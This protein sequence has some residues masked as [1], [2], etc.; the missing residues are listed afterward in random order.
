MNEVV[1]VIGVG[2][3]GS[4]GLRPQALARI[5]AAEF[6]AGG[7]R[8]L[9]YFPDVPAERFVIKGE[10]WSLPDE[11]RSRLDRKQRCVVLASGDPLFYGIGDYLARTLGRDYVRM[12]PT[13][14]SMQ[15]AFARARLRWDGARLSS[16]HGRDLRP[17]LLQLL[18]F[19]TIGLFSHDG[20]SPAE[21]ARFFLRYGASE[22]HALV[23]EN[24][25]AS[26]ERVT[27]CAS[28]VELV[29]QRFAPLN[30]LILWHGRVK[31]SVQTELRRGSVPGVQDDLFARPADGLEVMTRQEVRSVVLGKLC[32]PTEPGDT[33]WDIGAGLGTV[34]LEMAVL[35]PHLEVLAVEKD[36][37]RLEFLRENRKQFA[38]YNV[39]VIEGTAPEALAEE[40]E[41]PKLVFLGGS[42]G[43][44]AAILD[45]VHERLLHGGRLVANFVT[46]EHLTEMLARV[47][48]W[49]WQFEVTEISVSRSDG[50]AGLT[51]LKPQRSVFLVQADKPG[52]GHA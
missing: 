49:G 10:L 45:L 32:W 20:D 23:A 3:D 47:K 39:R 36:A 34:S 21:V 51:G 13:V 14:S 11:L 29:D 17:V 40:S 25:G 27:E 35:R 18:G 30:Y 8:H 38:V 42:G 33:F 22:Y 9:T 41:R 50:L 12:E 2:A 31:H 24:L 7:E 43:W 46:L 44:L 1:D 48:A 52:E 26:D 6:L 28:L 16:I 19:P 15:L 5:E 37:Q 4:A